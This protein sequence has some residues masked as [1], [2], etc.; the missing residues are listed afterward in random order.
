M[1]WYDT[2]P[3]IS[4]VFDNFGHNSLSTADYEGNGYF[5]VHENLVSLPGQSCYAS[6]RYKWS[7][8]DG[9]LRLVEP[10][11]LDS[12]HT[13]IDEYAATWTTLKD[14]A[15]YTSSAFN[16][17]VSVISSGES[18]HPLELIE[19]DN[20]SWVYFAIDNGQTGWI[21]FSYDSQAGWSVGSDSLFDVLSGFST[22]G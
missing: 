16:S 1:I 9:I 8:A 18:I 2:E 10:I 11:E 12:L 5:I 13:S 15:C 19:E 20:L 6:V 3:H 4:D 17:T 22:A 7:S 14:I 21:P